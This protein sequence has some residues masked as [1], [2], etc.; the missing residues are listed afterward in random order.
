MSAAAR[1]RR[2][3]RHATTQLVAQ[4]AVATGF[5][6]GGDAS[7]APSP[8]LPLEARLATS[9]NSE[10]MRPHAWCNVARSAGRPASCSASASGGVSV[11]TCCAAASHGVASTG[12]AGSTVSAAWDAR[13]SL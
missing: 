7:D 3:R 1:T 6:C 12:V 10:K 2:A 9:E 11:T 5:D 4:Q 13:V 8:P